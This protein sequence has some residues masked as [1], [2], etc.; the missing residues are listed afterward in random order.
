TDM[1]YQVTHSITPPF[2]FNEFFEAMNKYGY[3]VRTVEDKV[4]RNALTEHALK[5][6]DTVLFPLLHIQTDHLP[7]TTSSPEMRDTNTQRVMVCKPGFEATPR[8]STELVGTYLAY[9]VKT[10]FLPRP[11]V[12]GDDDVLTLPDL[13]TRV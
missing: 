9:M 11:A 10:G 6:Q 7:G 3:K 5:S 2:R 1:V 13:G 12:Q 4:W 8:M